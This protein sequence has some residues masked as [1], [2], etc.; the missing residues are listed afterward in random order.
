MKVL[1][2][3]ARPECSFISINLGNNYEEMS[4]ARWTGISHLRRNEFRL[5]WI[6]IWNRRRNPGFL[7]W[8]CFYLPTRRL[9]KVAKDS[10]SRKW[11]LPF[12]SAESGWCDDCTFLLNFSI[13]MD[14]FFIIRCLHCTLTNQIKLPI[15]NFHRSNFFLNFHCYSILS[16][17]FQFFFASNSIRFCRWLFSQLVRNYF[18]WNKDFF[19]HEIE[20]ENFEFHLIFK[21]YDNYSIH[22]RLQINISKCSIQMIFSTYTGWVFD[23]NIYFN[24]GFLMSKE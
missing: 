23:L 11:C 17:S 22:F 8:R 13:V 24:H 18:L 14:Q 21:L 5:L 1:Y 16:D 15:F 20:M 3:S 19:I 10:L 6:S 12:I 2:T 7:Y 4:S 9:W